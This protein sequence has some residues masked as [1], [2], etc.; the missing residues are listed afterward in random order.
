MPVEGMT[1]LERTVRIARSAISDVVLIG[2]APFELPDSLREWPLI[3]D[4]PVGCGP[5]GGLAGFFHVS[6]DSDC[7]LLAC[8]MPYLDAELLRR[9]M[10]AVLDDVDAVVPRCPAGGDS[11]HPCC[12]LY[13]STAASAVFEAVAAGRLAMR[14]L[15]DRL[16]V[17]WI[18]L[19]GSD[20][21]WVVNLNTPDEAAI[22]HGGG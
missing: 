5:I 3:A 21:S 8:D 4:A 1:L 16:R 17:R 13:R 19:N 12:A 20:A 6:P 14:G 9:L 10:A 11:V 22:H 18:S 2:H 7:I 15:L